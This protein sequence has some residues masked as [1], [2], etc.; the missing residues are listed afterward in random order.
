MSGNPH[1][2]MIGVVFMTAQLEPFTK[3]PY[4]D[5]EF[6]VKIVLDEYV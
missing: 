1:D 4:F 2:G 5:W 6:M 3:A